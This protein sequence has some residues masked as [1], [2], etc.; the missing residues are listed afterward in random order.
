MLIL[1]K[2]EAKTTMDRIARFNKI[3]NQIINKLR[4]NNYE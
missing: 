2:K 4:G 1:L 3:K